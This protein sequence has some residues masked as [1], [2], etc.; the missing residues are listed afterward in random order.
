MNITKSGLTKIAICT[1]LGSATQLVSAAAF[2]QAAAAPAAVP[3]APAQ[4]QPGGPGAAS[5]PTPPPAVAEPAPAPAVV[6]P[7]PGVEPA[8]PP[9]AAAPPPVAEA[10]PADVPPEAPKEDALPAI[11][12]GAWLRVGLQFQGSSDPKKLNDQHFDT[13]YGELHVGG[14]V[15]K[16]VSYTLNFNA[17][18]KGGKPGI[19]D[20][21]IGLDFMDE[22][23]IWSGQLLTPVDRTNFS[24]PFFISPWT[25]PGIMGVGGTTV[26]VTPNGE[27]VYGRDVGSVIWGDIQKGTFKYYAA[28]THLAAVNESPLFS[29]RLAFAAIGKEPGYYGS[30]TYY[31]DQ[32]VLALGVGAQVQKD[33]SRF[34]GTPGS[35]PGVTPVVPA[36]PPA[37]AN[38]S[39]VNA[40][41]LAEFKLGESG[42]LTGEAAVYHYSGDYNPADNQFFIVASYLSPA[43]GPGKLQPLFRYQMA[44]KKDIDAM[45]QIDVQL[46]Y[47]MKGASM[48][49]LIGFSHTDLGKDV[50]GN[51]I[52]LGLQTI[53]F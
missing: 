50:V 21:I 3:P 39:E 38:Y 28:M 15:H 24:G 41:L 16:N 35:A 46:A 25:Y 49:G 51:A 7:V 40:D 1:A 48:R 6:T 26:F 20:A 4:P 22:F 37:A 33:G 14:K 32:D 13:V 9:P 8:P 31:G 30:S 42:A 19:M 27:D 43:V 47:A 10:K 23:H 11:D 18:G 17:S 2:A 45:S 12:V 29:G 53:M 44:K 5:G 36:V 52:Q 34:A